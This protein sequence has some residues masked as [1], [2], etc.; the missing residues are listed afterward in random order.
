MPTLRTFQ[1]GEHSDEQRSH[2]ER[3]LDGKNGSEGCLLCHANQA[4]RSK[5]VEVYQ[6]LPECYQ[7]IVAWMRQ[8]GCQMITYIDD[9]LLLASSKEE[10]Q[11]QTKLMV[12]LFEALGFSVNYKKSVLDPQQLMEFLGFQID[13]RSMTIALHNRT[14]ASSIHWE[15]QLGNIS[16]HTSSSVLSG[17]ARSETCHSYAI[18]GP[19]FSHL[20]Y[21]S[22]EGG[23]VVVSG[24]GETLERIQP[25][26]SISV[27]KDSNGFLEIGLGSSLSRD[28]DRW[29]M[30]LQGKSISHQ[31]PG[32]VDSISDNSIICEE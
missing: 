28:S 13:S 15:S 1:N 2:P 23:A 18:S 11:V 10:A 22:R 3:R 8:F 14:E 7:S 4:G 21:E 30:D 26:T 20:G 17:A 25:E 29:S 6:L 31:L 27:P 16:H 24:A 19:R 32:V 5:I 12:V 9:N